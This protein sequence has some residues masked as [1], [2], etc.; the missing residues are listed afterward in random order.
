MAFIQL[1]EV[2]T[3]NF[4]EITALVDEWRAQTEGA[5]TATR[6]TTVQ[7]RD[8]PNTYIQIVEFASYEDA[9]ANSS[10]PT[11]AAFAEK[12]AALCDSPPSF[13]NLEVLRVED[14]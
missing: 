2:T 14:M 10:L 4:D 13:R 9:M 5:R 12:L 1:I 7:D 8:R 11:T 3:T 6:A